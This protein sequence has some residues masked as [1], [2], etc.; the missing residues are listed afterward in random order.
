MR[1]TPRSAA[2]CR[3]L[4]PAV[5][6]PD[7]TRLRILLHSAKC[8]IECLLLCFTPA[9]SEHAYELS[10]ILVEEAD[11]ESFLSTAAAP[12]L[13]EVV[14][15][16]SA[17]YDRAGSGASK[18][19][20]T[21]HV[22][23]HSQIRS[24]GYGAAP[25]RRPAWA[26]KPASKGTGKG[27]SFVRPASAAYPSIAALPSNLDATA[28]NSGA[29]SS[30]PPAKAAAG[31][32]GGGARASDSSGYD[33]GGAVAT[34]AF[35]SD[36]GELG[37]S[38]HGGGLHA[39]RFQCSAPGTAAGLPRVR[40]AGAMHR[41][42]SAASSGRVGA[43]AAAGGE[44]ERAWTSISWGAK[45]LELGASNSKGAAPSS[46]R[47]AG[48]SDSDSGTSL[49]ALL[50]APEGAA[51]PTAATD[52]PAVPGGATARL[53]LGCSGGP[54]ACMWLSAGSMKEPV[55]V[56]CD[57]EGGDMRP[58]WKLRGGSGSA[59]AT[60]AA[61]SAASKPANYTAGCFF[62]AD[63]F[64]LLASGGGIS[65]FT[66]SLDM[67]A[68]GGEAGS[69][70]GGSLRAAGKPARPEDVVV[71]RRKQQP[72]STYQRAAWWQAAPD[73]FSV[74]ALA[75]HNSFRSGL[76]LAAC[77]DRALR[78]FDVAVASEP[79]EVLSLLEAHE[80]PIHTLA[81]PMAS[82][83]SDASAA[84]LTAAVTASTEAGGMVKLWDLRTAALACRFTGGHVNRVHACGVSLSADGV[85]LATGSE[86]RAAVIYDTRM[87]DAPVAK[88]RGATD[89][90]TAV[91][92][93]PQVPALL[94]GGLD[95][96]CRIYQA[97]A[98]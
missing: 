71:L 12:E 68:L 20:G 87:P 52:K 37:V 49:S 67:E 33:A 40:A 66:F 86:D 28:W 89:A 65:A 74:S 7:Q 59:S 83:Y 95:G 8:D 24:S 6:M 94:V 15:E 9:M 64:A 26:A 45:P 14:D 79:A 35:S 85:Y 39:G 57:A 10:A 48:G 25:P 3:T 34:L 72:R 22:V 11:S 54:E 1:R 18:A 43:G 29:G 90:V 78:V 16:G 17:S 92:F 30:I 23:F 13:L 50:E 70:A 77:S 36:G 60:P 75:A 55:L 63:K 98:L 42:L 21:K 53:L 38:A 73:G 84:S 41:K 97:Q 80:R 76:V 81:L 32:R 2:A 58:Y 47:R 56:I 46:A 69:A 62:Y 82:P 96:L 93:H 19:S 91:A 31:V 5:R 4:R 44:S 61:A 51:A 88:L 27:A